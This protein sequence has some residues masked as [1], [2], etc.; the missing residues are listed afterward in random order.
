MI[1]GFSL[2]TNRVVKTEKTYT[3]KKEGCGAAFSSEELARQHWA[4]EHSVQKVVHIG[5]FHPDRYYQFASE[6]DANLWIKYVYKARQGFPYFKWKGPGFYRVSHGTLC[7][8]QI[9]HVEDVIAK[10]LLD[11]QR[12]EDEIEGIRKRVKIDG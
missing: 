10:K 7:G 8:S 3:C 12:I 2:Q 6:Y 5:D 11:I 1:P 9:E 4:H